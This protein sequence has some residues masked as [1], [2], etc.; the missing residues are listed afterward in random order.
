MTNKIK[1]ATAHI[2][3]IGVGIS[4]GLLEAPSCLY[5]MTPRSILKPCFQMRNSTEKKNHPLINSGP[6]VQPI[7]SGFGPPHSSFIKKMATDLPIHQSDGGVP[8]L[9]FL[10]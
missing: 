1:S 8:Q 10:S 2:C 3:W 6:H 9:R 4:L 5:L 7:D